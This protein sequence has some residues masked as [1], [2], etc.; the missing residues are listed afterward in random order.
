MSESLFCNAN[1][2]IQL[3]MLKGN[4]YI[5]NISE[6]FEIADVGLIF[7]PPAA[8]QRVETYGNLYFGAQ[9]L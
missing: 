7:K 4:I 2:S 3:L 1:S 9:K 8:I 6:Y 5:A